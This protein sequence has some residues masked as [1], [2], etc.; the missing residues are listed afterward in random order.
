MSPT[1]VVGVDGGGTSLRAVVATRDLE[2]V[3]SSH[4][5]GANPSVL[6][7]TEAAQRIIAAVR[8]ALADAGVPPEAVAAAAL[9]IAGAAASHSAEWLCQVARQALP[10]AR[11]VPSADYEIAL[12]GANGRLEG[13][14]ISAGTGSVAYGVNPQGRSALAGGWGY[15]LGDEGSGYWLGREGL[16]ALTLA[17]D[18]RGPGT[19]L[20]E[21]LPEALGLALDRTALI[22]WLYAD[23]TSRVGEIAALAPAVLAAADRGDGVAADIVGRA[24]RHLAGLGRAV[25]ARLGLACPQYALAGGLLA[26]PNPLSTALCQQLGLPSIPK[27][28]YP[29]ALG[30]AILALRALGIAH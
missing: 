6:G 4:T 9:G 1:F 11:V 18:G 20:Q 26:Q 24:A 30:A 14:L 29:P 17:Q 7:R 10:T 8:E 5:A 13:V 22:R 23:P 3:G 15:L 19:V 28:Q 27:P 2:V 12:A 25:A 16:R 21:S